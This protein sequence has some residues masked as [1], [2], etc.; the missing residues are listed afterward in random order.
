MNSGA[1]NG[2]SWPEPR[3]KGEN[4]GHSSPRAQ[5]L[6]RLFFAMSSGFLFFFAS[7]EIA[8]GGFADRGMALRM[9]YMAVGSSRGHEEDLGLARHVEHEAPIRFA[10]SVWL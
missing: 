8:R 1:T 2:A 6:F 9:T 7:C 3:R 5:G 10:F 4:W